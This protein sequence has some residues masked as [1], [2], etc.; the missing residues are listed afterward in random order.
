[1]DKQLTIMIQVDIKINK[2]VFQNEK[3]GREGN[4]EMLLRLL[5]DC[6]NKMEINI[7]H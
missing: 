6:C 4:E 7:H 1:M 5:E 3:K 2:L